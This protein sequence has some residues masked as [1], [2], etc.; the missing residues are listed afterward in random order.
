MHEIPAET[1]NSNIEYCIDEYVRNVQ[2]R[3]MLRDKWFRGM[4][5][6]Q[7]AQKYD[8]ST[9]TTK[10]VIYDIGDPILL[11]ASSMTKKSG[12]I[13]LVAIYRIADILKQIKEPKQVSALR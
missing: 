1:L 3:E 7:I 11:R 13:L 4:S 2:H 12:Q 10:K 8:V 6:E 5:L 9:T